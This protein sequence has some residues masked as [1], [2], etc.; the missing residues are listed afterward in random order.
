MKGFLITGTDTDV[1]KTWFMLKFAELLKEH[2][3][4]FHFLKPVESGCE[5]PTEEIIPKRRGKILTVKTHLFQIYV[6][7][8]LKL[9]HPHQEQQN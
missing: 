4:K 7:L 5:E 3:F 2:K 6:G 8:C 9:M 1:G